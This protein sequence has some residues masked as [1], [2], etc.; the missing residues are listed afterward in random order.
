LNANAVVEN[1]IQNCESAITNNF[2]ISERN[3]QYNYSQSSIFNPS[4]MPISCMFIYI[5]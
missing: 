4:N 1:H 2:S 5:L 3:N